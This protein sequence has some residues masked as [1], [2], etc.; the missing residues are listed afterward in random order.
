MCVPRTPQPKRRPMKRCEQV[1]TL[2]N[3]AATVM[4][5]PL[6]SR[7]DCSMRGIAPAATL[8]SAALLVF[9][10][11]TPASAQPR[12]RM[13]PLAAERAMLPSGRSR[14]IV[15]AA[16]GQSLPAV[17]TAVQAAGGTVQ[18]ALPSIG[19][20]VVDLPNPALAALATESAISRIALD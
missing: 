4:S 9:V 3:R 10:W 2:L 8:I 7:R 6:V 14:I 5:R 20:Y 12:A 16:D 19:G 11:T 18:R 1:R 13:G 17:A 15:V